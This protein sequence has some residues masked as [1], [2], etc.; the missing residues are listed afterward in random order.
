VSGGII[1]SGGLV[2]ST[3]DN[4]AGHRTHDTRQHSDCNDRA[5]LRLAR[6][7]LGRRTY[8]RMWSAARCP[9]LW[10]P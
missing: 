2:K 5:S 4:R 6:Y 9:P 7:G 8:K 10:L 1:A 3:S